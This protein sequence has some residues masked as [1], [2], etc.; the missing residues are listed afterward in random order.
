[1]VRFAVIMGV[2]LAVC[3]PFGTGDLYAAGNLQKTLQAAQ[4]RCE[5]RTEPLGIDVLRPR[6]S[7]I[8]Q[9]DARGQKQTAY[10]ILVAASEKA[11]AAD[12]GDLWDSGKVASDETIGAVYAGKPLTSMQRCF[13]KVQV[14]DG[15]DKPSVWSAPARWSMGLLQP[16]DWK[17]QW[18]GCDVAIEPSLV[19]AEFQTA[20]W[21]G[22]AD[23]KTGNAQPVEFGYRTT[24]Q[25]PDTSKIQ[26]AS[27]YMAGDNK[28]KLYVNG[29]AAGSEVGFSSAQK[30]DCIS[31]LKSGLNAL[32]FTVVNDG[33][34]PNPTGL[35]AAL[36]IELKDGQKI[37]VQ[38]G[39]SWRVA[40]GP[41]G[42]WVTADF[43]DSGWEKAYVIGE[44]GCRPW[45]KVDLDANILPP[46]QYL[47]SQFSA[48]KSVRR[49]TLYTTAFGIYQL[50]LNGQRISK[51]YFSPGWTDYNKRIYYRT[52][53]VTS[54]IKRGDNAIG[55]IL[56]DGWYAGYVGYGKKRNHYGQK[57]RLLAQ[58]HIEY[59]DGTTQDVFTNPDWKGTTGPI[60]QADFLMG[61]TYDATKE[62]TGWNEPGYADAAWAKVSTGAEL[63]PQVQAAPSEPVVVF[64][65]VKPVSVSEPTKGAYVFN[66]GQNFAG[67]VRLKV[68]GAAGQPVQLRFA[69]RLNPDGTIYTTNLRAAKATDVYI[70]KGK[71]TE[72]WEPMFTFHGFQY[73][74]I[75]G[76]NYKPGKDT[77]TGLAF[78]SDT[79]VAGTFE[80][81]APM[82]N[83]LHSNIYWTQRMNF[84]DIPTDC[85]QRD[86]RLGWTG[87]AQVYI[88]TAAMNTDVHAFFIKWLQD[89][90]DAQRNDGQFP[91]VA[92][93]KVAESDGGPAWA[94]A[95]VICP[96]TAYQVYG[97]KQLLERQYPSMVKFI[98]FCKNRSTPELLPP[99]QFHCFG[100]WLNIDDNTPNDVIYTA[101]FALSTKMTAQAAQV[102][103]K[104]EDA[105]KYNELYQG[106]KAA[107]NK[108]YVAADGKIKGDT[109]TAYVLAIAVDLVDCPMYQTVANRLVELIE[110]RNWHLSTGFIGTKDLMLVLA[111][112][113]RNDVA[114]RLL[115]NDTFPSWGFSIKHGATSIWE[116]WNGWTPEQGFGDPGMNSFAHY[117]FGAVYQWM[118]EN[119]GGIQADDVAYRKILIKPC[120]DE[121][122]TWAKTSYDSI[123]GKIETSW[124]KNKGTFT[125]DITIPANTTA[126]V[127]V[128]AASMESITESGKPLNKAAGI[129]PINM[130]KEITGQQVQDYA[131]LRLESG[132]YQFKTKL[133]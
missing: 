21:I 28:A 93:L 4:L 64:E 78:S 36:V 14:W 91:M 56:A 19:P 77:I 27:C 123:R 100:D 10:R 47:R 63:T 11:L 110:K 70:C 83:Q 20:K 22:P 72:V 52:Y 106:I 103:G 24:V 31:L 51:D 133:K 54:A 53:D 25:V 85:P 125:L 38:T 112:I 48:T 26:S 29:K 34:P 13:W 128:P 108:A 7:W 120:L 118:V 126:T 58:L 98:E 44:A 23:M 79:P 5:Y 60:L 89:L 86:E 41:K 129:N 3:N 111:K 62:L 35:L 45:G 15:N 2:V 49:A 82:I 1:M 101:Y 9:S 124:K 109:Q 57:L 46:A 18:V 104:T 40:A 16:Q 95:G 59:S 105:R 96:W 76:L 94:D 102:L 8:L 88:R 114:C 32:A 17:A 115:H 67:V 119:L 117:S 74:E 30:V 43:D 121:K 107:F 87:D 84:I 37:A 55:A 12:Q 61:E 65:E 73:V 122:L 68:K 71:G 90:A 69:E 92:P 127:Y 50:Y 131:V 116:R 99:A 113:G 81:S 42:K 6:L 132:Q 97:D 80:C 33:Q 39:D 66:M 75:T 130:H